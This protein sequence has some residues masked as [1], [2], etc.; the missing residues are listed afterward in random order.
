MKTKDDFFCIFQVLSANFQFFL[1]FA[2]L[3]WSINVLM[4]L[5]LEI[6]QITVSNS[7]IAKN[8]RKFLISRDCRRNIFKQKGE[9]MAANN[10]ANNFI[11]KVSEHKRGTF[12]SIPTRKVS[13]FIGTEFRYIARL[14]ILLT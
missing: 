11:T 10:V 9:R 12:T 6:S 14:R 3:Q 4:N 7:E 8:F 1:N 5:R 2:L 13:L